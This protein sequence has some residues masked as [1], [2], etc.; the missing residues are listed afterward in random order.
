MIKRKQKIRILK[1]I[2]DEDKRKCINLNLPN[3]IP[4]EFNPFMVKDNN[5]FFIDTKKYFYT[6]VEEFYRIIDSKELKIPED[7]S[8]LSTKFNP[9]QVC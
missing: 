4:E 5:E 8:L 1:R 6:F 7:L 9:C 2:W 3:N